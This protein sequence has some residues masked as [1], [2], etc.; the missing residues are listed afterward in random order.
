MS[1]EQ[2]A[3]AGEET[4]VRVSAAGDGGLVDAAGQVRFG[5]FDAPLRRVDL[6]ETP[7]R[8]G[9][10]TAPD[11]LARLRLKQWQHVGLVLPDAFVGLAL[12]DA[13]YLRTT[14]CHVVDRRTGAHFEHR[15][16]APRLDMKIARELWDDTCHVRARGYRVEIR[17]HLERGEHLVSLDVAEAR[18]RPA[19]RGELRC[20]HDLE[21]IEPLVV[22]LPVGPNRGMYS[23]KVA[24]PLEGELSVG[25]EPVEVDAQSCFA[26]W[27]IHKAH[28]PRRTWWNWATFAGR[29]SAG[30][31]LAMNLTRNVV[32]DD[33]RYNENAV[34]V[35]GRIQRP[36]PALFELD[37]ERPLEPWRL[38]SAC[39]RV[40]LEFRPEGE[41]SENLR[42][43][44]VKSVFHQPYGTFHGRVRHCSEELAVDGLFGVCEDHEAA[45]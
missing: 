31:A 33:T 35:E 25:G 43:G 11:A 27:D 15:R 36:G 8:L 37:R 29:D 23:H 5:V 7:L 12:V 34:W 45:W 17:N 14:W 39:G 6:D 24:L 19:V 9:G 2:Q 28:Y 16:M 41:R 21:A 26:I 13:A 40:D 32:K 18:G 30:H 20:A 10:V 3:A 1:R 44:L 4:G 22:C 38:R 42:L